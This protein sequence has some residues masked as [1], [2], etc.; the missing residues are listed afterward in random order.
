MKFLGGIPVDQRQEELDAKGQYDLALMEQAKANADFDAAK[1]L[2]DVA[3]NERDAAK[4]DEKSAQSR[5]KAA[6]T[7][8]DTTRI[9]AAEDEMKGARLAADAADKRYAY[10]TAYRTWIQRVIRYTEHNVF[11]KEA[12]YELA[13][14][15]IAKKNTIAPAGFN[16]DNFVKQ[17]SDRGKKV[18][19]ARNR[20]ESEKKTAM[21]ARTKW[22][23]LQKESDKL[24]GKTS[25]YPDPLNP[26][27]LQGVDSK[28]Y[29]T[30]GGSVG[31][32]K[33]VEPTQ[34]PTMR[35]PAPDEDMEESGDD[36]DESADPDEGGE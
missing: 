7:S 26:E 18:G 10:L 6:Q 19:D 31:S 23:A 11:W 25:E 2:L 8:A 4:L 34:D 16:F 27:T 15:K 9:K 29:S 35:D 22:M 3:K 5:Q 14:A 13:Q 30:G 12:A 28:G 24:L 21:A 33:E 36:D 32:D 1:V 20:A 17:E